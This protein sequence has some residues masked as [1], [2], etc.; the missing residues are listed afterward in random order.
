MSH[1]EPNALKK[2]KKTKTISFIVWLTTN[3][4]YTL[5]VTVGA[6]MDV[7]LEKFRKGGVGFFYDPKNYIANFVGFKATYFGK[8]VQKGGGGQGYLEVFQ[9]NIHFCTDGRPLME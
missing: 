3:F 9:K 4:R 1:K 7:F 8:N 2:N 6:K 5:G